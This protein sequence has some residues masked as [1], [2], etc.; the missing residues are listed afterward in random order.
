MDRRL[1]FRSTDMSNPPTAGR[2]ATDIGGTFTD[3]VYLR[4]DPDT[5]HQ[6]IIT[7]KSDT[8]RPDF[9]RGVLDVIAKAGVSAA[10]V[11]FLVHGPHGCTARHARRRSPDEVM[12]HPDGTAAPHV[13]CEYGSRVPD[14]FSS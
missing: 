3:L 6:E 13:V 7:A 4:T 12:G 8:T 1:P 9:E 14:H 5:G 11:G 10:D 2:V